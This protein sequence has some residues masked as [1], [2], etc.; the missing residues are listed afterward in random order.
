MNPVKFTWELLSGVQTTAAPAVAI[1]QILFPMSVSLPGTN[2]PN[3][4]CDKSPVATGLLSH[5]AH[6]GACHNARTH[7]GSSE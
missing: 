1:I 6:F 7:L 5:N 4:L 3:L 2:L